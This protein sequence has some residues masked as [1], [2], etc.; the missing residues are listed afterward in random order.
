LAALKN[1]LNA[2][3]GLVGYSGN[4]GAAT[5]TSLALGGATLGTNAFAVAGTIVN[6]LDLTLAANGFYVNSV[7]SGFVEITNG[8]YYGFSST[9]VANAAQQADLKIYRDAAG[10]LA[11]RN[12]LNA[13][14]FRVYNT[15]SSTGTNYERGVLDWQTTSNVFRI[16]TE[17]GGTGVARPIKITS[18][19]KSVQYDTSTVAGLGSA[20]TAGAGARGY[21]TDGS[22]TPVGNFGNTVAGGGANAGPC[23]SD[24]A[25]WKWG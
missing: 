24:G 22:T 14:T 6:T 19:T 1:A 9:S 15:W 3:G 8:A 23:W 17:A 13:Q 20:A 25:N 18:A 10:I 16:G 11:Q 12:A 2:A 5:G 7:G 21:V 4:I